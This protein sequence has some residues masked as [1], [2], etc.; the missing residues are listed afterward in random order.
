VDPGSASSE[1]LGAIGA[2]GGDVT[3]FYQSRD[4]LYA[5]SPGARAQKLGRIE[6]GPSAA[7]ETQS[8]DGSRLIA[9]YDKES[10]ELDAAYAQPGSPFEEAEGLASLREAGSGPSISAADDGHGTVAVAWS[11]QPSKSAK[12]VIAAAVGSGSGGFGV[13]Q[14]LGN[15]NEE[16]SVRERRGTPQLAAADGGGIIATWPSSSATG[17][18]LAELPMGAAGFQASRELPVEP[19]S[20]GALLPEGTA[21]ITNGSTVEQLTPAGTPLSSYVVLGG[22]VHGLPALAIARDGSSALG[23][24]SDH[25][26]WLSTA[27]PG[28]QFGLLTPLGV[29]EDGLPN[30]NPYTVQ[31]IY[32]WPGGGTLDSVE[33]GNIETAPQSPD[34]FAVG[35]LPDPGVPAVGGSAFTLPGSEPD[36]ASMFTMNN[37]VIYELQRPGKF[38]HATPR[39]SAEV[40]SCGAPSGRSCEEL[41]VGNDGWCAP[42]ARCHAVIHDGAVD[43]QG[44]AEQAI[45]LVASAMVRTYSGWHHVDANP[46]STA[47]EPFER[48]GVH[49]RI[50]GL[51]ETQC[52]A[53]RRSYRLVVT[54][55]ARDSSGGTSTRTLR[56]TTASCMS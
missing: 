19:P 55:H 42:S 49:F 38:N 8:A 37:G 10:G 44:K 30:L 21:L 41:E 43:V 50:P 51:R 45:T 34:V 40:E 47:L 11:E 6:G 17:T 39:F 3:L 26:L 4:T 12:P 32:A 25:E 27:A 46:R 23:V 36:S 33:F 9:W 22:V 13:A 31:Q 29:V 1:L 24:V 28:G 16:S 5:L 52:P 35:P 20:A 7:V 18:M 48:Y 54:L 53:T 56:F 15:T 2:S 14:T